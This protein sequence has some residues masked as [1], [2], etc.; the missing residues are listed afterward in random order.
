MIHSIAYHLFSIFYAYVKYKI[1]IVIFSLTLVHGYNF[2]NCD[3]CMQN[4]CRVDKLR[5]SRLH[6]N[7]I[8]FSTKKASM[9]LHSKMEVII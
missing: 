3:K 8:D 1:F 7:L 6:S 2:T 4:L 5:F 9:V